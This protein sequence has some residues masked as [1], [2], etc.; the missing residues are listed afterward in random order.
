[1]KEKLIASFLAALMVA[2]PAALAASALNT[3]PAFLTT[4]PT[5]LATT[6]SLNAYVVVGSSGSAAGLAADIAGAID[7]ALRLTE[8]SYIKVTTEGG[9][10]GEYDGLVRDG[11]NICDIDTSTTANSCNLTKA[12]SGGTAFP[13]LIKNTHYSGLKE[14]KISWR[15][16]TYDYA[17]QMDATGVLM[18]HKL[19][20]ANINGTEKMVIGDSDIKYEF[21]FKRQIQGLGSPSDPNYSYPLGINLLG[22]GFT[23]VGVDTDSIL[24]LSGSTCSGATATNGCTYEDYTVYAIQG[25]ASF[26]Q[27]QIQDSAGNTVDTILVTGWSSGESV[28]KSSTATGLDI[29]VTA[30][31]ALQDGTVVGCDMV[32]G[33]TGTTTHDY[34]GIADVESTGIANEAFD[35]DNP[36]WGIQFSPGSSAVGTIASNAKIQVIYKPSA[37]EYYEAGEKLSLP[38]DYGDLGFEGWNTADFAAITVKPVG[39]VSVYNSTDAELQESYLYGIELSSDTAGVIYG[40]NDFY[41]KAYVLFNATRG[42]GSPLAIGWYDDVKGKILVNDNWKANNDVIGSGAV[43]TGTQYAYALLN[44]TSGGFTYS[45]VINNGEKNFYVYLSIANVTANAMPISLYAGDTQTSTSVAMGFLNATTWTSGPNKFEQH[46]IKL[47][48]TTGVAESTEL[49]V[50]TEAS[51]GND[52]NA[53]AKSREVVDDTGLLIQNPTT[54]SGSDAVVFKVPSKALAVKAY[55]GKKGAGTVVTGETVNKIVPITSPVALLDSEVTSTHKAKN[56]V[57][58]GGPCANSVTAEV[59][60][61]GQLVDKDGTQLTCSAWSGLTRKF[62]LIS[63]VDGAFTTGKTAVVVA[64]STRVETRIATE[65]LMKY[66]TL[67]TGVTDS[68]AEVTAATTAGITPF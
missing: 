21:V 16:S 65:V 11:I 47:G 6:N 43:S 67:L 4:D 62:G 39:P 3:Y 36:R 29:T 60:N 33:P 13:T 22:K 17:E 51:T 8:M 38:N 35:A 30:I 64:G 53:G 45:F 10:T 27:L 28:T 26:V 66:D 59:A 32:V 24:M 19:A 40:G 25:G 5:L 37:I 41:T 42:A 15:S 31:A 49:N 50:T 54:N 12:V 56:I 2:T 46:F 68:A 44:Q 58:V 9:V 57:L 18:R 1:M 63:A 34:D 7:L 14:G 20:A 23:I 55:F 61:A 48:S 52:R